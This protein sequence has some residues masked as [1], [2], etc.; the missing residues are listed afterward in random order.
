[1]CVYVCTSS[2]CVRVLIEEGMAGECV[3]GREK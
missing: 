3:R 1:M 2:A